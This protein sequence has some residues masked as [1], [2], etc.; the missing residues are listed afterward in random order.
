MVAPLLFYY[1]ALVGL[2]TYIEHHT[3]SAVV[4]ERLIELVDKFVY[5]TKIMFLQYSIEVFLHKKKKV[6]IPT[7]N[8]PTLK[9]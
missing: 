3:I 9:I 5:G 8:L 4:C 6:V 1:T 7:T 2:E